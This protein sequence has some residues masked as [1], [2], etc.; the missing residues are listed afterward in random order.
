MSLTPLSGCCPGR[1]CESLGL[2]AIVLLLSGCGGASAQ[3]ERV[4]TSAAAAVKAPGYLEPAERPDSVALL[5]PPPARGS[6][7][8][9][10]DEDIYRRLSALVG[11]AR[12]RLAAA[13]ADLKFP[14]AANVFACALG[15]DVDATRTPHLYT[16]L[17]R[18][19]IDAGQS[20]YPAKLKYGT[21]RPFEETGDPTCVPADERALRGNASYPSGH[22]SLGYVWGE[23]LAQVLPDRAPALRA[24]GYEFGQSRVVCRVHR[25]SDVDAGRMVGQAVMPRLQQDPEFQADLAAARIEAQQARKRPVAPARDCNA[26][27]T[28]LSAATAPI[29]ARP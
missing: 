19:I 6:A 15:I 12:W 23:V 7:E 25:Q 21:S 22:A 4:A 3:S 9:R 14:H 1:R 27:A 10:S 17:Q 18:T 11:T 24:R 8:Y 13:D 29:A 20:T 5:P 16:L 2:L 26:E 28:A